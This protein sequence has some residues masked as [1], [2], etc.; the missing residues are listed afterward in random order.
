MCETHESITLEEFSVSQTFF[1]LF[2]SCRDIFHHMHRENVELFSQQWTK[3]GYII[4]GDQRN[5]VHQSTADLA[6]NRNSTT[7]MYCKACGILQLWILCRIATTAENPAWCV[8]LTKFVQNSH[9]IQGFLPQMF[10]HSRWHSPYVLF[11][12]SAFWYIGF[13][14]SQHHKHY[15]SATWS[16]L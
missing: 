3:L 1:R 12:Y 15:K 10:T 6:Q 5:D 7:F 9:R 16:G 2:L 11:V 13:H 8:E 14:F 4:D